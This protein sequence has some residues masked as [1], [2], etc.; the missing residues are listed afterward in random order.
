MCCPVPFCGRW[1]AMVQ[2][3]ERSPPTNVIRSG[4]VPYVGWVFCWFSPWT[5]VFFRR[6]LRFSFFRKN[7][8]SKFQFDQD[9]DQRRLG[10]SQQRITL[11][12]IRH[13]GGQAHYY[14]HTGSLKQRP[15]KLDW[16]RS[17]CFNLPSAGIIMSLHSSIV[18]CDRLLQKAYL[19]ILFTIF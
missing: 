15:V 14:S 1:A 6:V 5:D 18:P 7:Q 11:Y 2:R 8:H 17:L 9:R 3:W 13:A 10:L 12:K 4:S 19:G 16:L